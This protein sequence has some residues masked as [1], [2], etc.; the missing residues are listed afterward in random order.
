MSENDVPSGPLARLRAQLAGPRGYRRIESLLS[1]DDAEAA[2]AALAPNEVFALVHEVGFE[3]GQA[4]LEYATPV[5]FQGC[6]DLDGWSRDQLEVAPIKPWLAATIEVGFERVGE[7]WANLDSELRALI[8]QRCVKVYDVS[9]GEEPAD[10]N[11][12]EIMATPDRMFMLELSGDED[13]KRLIQR[14]VED[15]YRA[16]P[17][18]ARH[19]IMAAR[20]EPAA[21]LEE[22]S[23]RW[24]AGRLAD[25]GYVD[26]YDALDLFRPLPADQVHVGEGSQDRASTYDEPARLPV[27]VAEQV[28]GRSFLARAL[29]AIDDQADAERLEGALV[30]LVNKVLAAGRAKPGEPEVVKRG[31]LY[32]TAT[33]SLGL[34]T[35]ARGDLAKATQALGSVSIGRLFRVGYTVTA[36]LAKLAT[37]LANR[38]QT[39][40]SPTKELVAGLCSPRP[41]FAC[42]ADTPPQ[43]GL[44]PFES[45][46][47][48]RRAGELLAALTIEIALVEGFGVDVVAMG[49]A[50]EPRP[51]LGDYVRTALARAIAG[52]ELRAEALSQAELTALRATGFSAAAR[53]LGHAAITSRLGAAQLAASG[54]I[55]TKLVDGWLDDLERILGDI[56]DTVIDPR[57]VEGVIVENREGVH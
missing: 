39:A 14:L 51:G 34:E 37:A 56:T 49:Q 44:R 54:A 47:D 38:S 2:I 5:Q 21:E 23:Y 42:A 48:L 26:F 4:L 6:I 7:V 1:Q 53:R 32:A 36:R 55:I 29:A 40:G 15:L 16:D 50:P 13:T 28:V 24:R 33:L 10:D 43:P 9:L 22:Q 27:L 8:L 19:T 41:L 45:Q 17:D 12:E 18:L 25:L 31:A 57:F 20:S 11:E 35:V 46:V 30:V 52:G 3:D